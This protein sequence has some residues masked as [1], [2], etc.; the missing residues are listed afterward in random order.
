MRRAIRKKTTETFTTSFCVWE[1]KIK[2]IK[3]ENV[4]QT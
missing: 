3:L 4:F 1:S 2:N